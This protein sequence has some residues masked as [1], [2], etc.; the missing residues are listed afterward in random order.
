VPRYFFHVNKDIR[1]TE[2]SELAGVAEARDQAI[3]SAGE[4]IRAADGETVWNG[5]DWRMDVTDEAGDRLFALRFSADDYGPGCGPMALRG[6]R[7][8]GSV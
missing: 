1:D 3:I 6:S 5:S 2:G 8:P 4:M 7:T